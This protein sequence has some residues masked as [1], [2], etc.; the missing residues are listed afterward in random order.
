MPQIGIFLSKTQLARVD[1]QQIM[2]G[3]GRSGVIQDLVNRYTP[4]PIEKKETDAPLPET[5]P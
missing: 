2:L 3:T 5:N 1:Y 4:E